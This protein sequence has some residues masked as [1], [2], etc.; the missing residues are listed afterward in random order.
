[1]KISS[2]DMAIRLNTLFVV[3]IYLDYIYNIT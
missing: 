1:M 3:E 2:L